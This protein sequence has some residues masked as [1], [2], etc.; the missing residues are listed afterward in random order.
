MGFI[1]S[2]NILLVAWSLDKKTTSCS[3]FKNIFRHNLELIGNKQNELHL[4]ISSYLVHIPQGFLNIL[5]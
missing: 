3:V 1:F 2:Q 4:Y 5:M